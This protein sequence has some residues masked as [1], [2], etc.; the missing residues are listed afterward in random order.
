MEALIPMNISTL[1]GN[2]ARTYG[3]RPAVSMGDEQR[4]TYSEMYGRVIRLAGGLR[5]VLGLKVGDRVVLA[6]NNRSQY[7]EILFAIWHA[8]LVA[9]PVNAKLHA[10]EV[11]FI[12]ENCDASLCLATEEHAEAIALL[13]GSG[14]RPVRVV[15]VDGPDYASLFHEPIAQTD[16]RRDDLAW[17]FYTSGTTGRPK[18]AMLSH[19][20]LQLMTWSYLCDFDHIT[21]GDALLHLGPQSHAAGLMSLSFIAKG[22][23][24]V[25]PVSGGVDASEIALL[26]NQYENLTF[27][28]APTMTRRLVDSPDIARCDIGHVR[29]IIGGGAPFF[30]SDVKRV[31]EVFG[32]RFINAYGQGECPCTITG[33]PKHLYTSDVTEERLVSVGVARSGVDVRIVDGDNREVAAGEAGEIAVRS[34]IV[35]NGYWKQPQATAETVRD[36]WLHTGDMGTMDD[37]GFVWLKDR[38]KDVIISGGSNIYP[39]EVEDVL[40]S[41][42]GVAE[43]AVVGESDAKWGEAV[44]AFVVARTGHSLSA[45]SLDQLCLDNLA[46]YKRPKRYVFLDVL[47][48]NST[49][50]VLRTEL[51]AKLKET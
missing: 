32:S 20:N 19:L 29:S 7:L 23:N 34:P 1:L 9:V 6:M 42:I 4:F 28:A 22:A 33:M 26:I 35:M 3:A 48:K 21:D 51:R 37:R 38:A 13:A 36:G 5:N 27:F 16:V 2:A 17:L 12:L 18:G 43:V 49:G 40:C 44:V 45:E 11:A 8:G 25:L 39:R 41:D 14:E 24:N 50:K 30:A 15:C 46:R 10:R 47:P 31:I